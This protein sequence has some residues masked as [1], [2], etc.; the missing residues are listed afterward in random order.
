MVSDSAARRRVAARPP[1]GTPGQIGEEGMRGL[2]RLL[3]EFHPGPLR[4]GRL[5]LATGLGPRPRA[6]GQPPSPCLP[7][8]TPG[9]CGS[10][11]HTAVPPPLPAGF[12]P[13]GLVSAPSPR[14]HEPRAGAWVLAGNLSL[15]NRMPPEPQTVS[16]TDHSFPAP[17]EAKGRYKGPP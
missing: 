12:C 14:P 10:T 16:N 1:G 9:K 15:T 3:P 8:I 5:C 17:R 13:G 7:G 4:T 11:R 2:R 6:E